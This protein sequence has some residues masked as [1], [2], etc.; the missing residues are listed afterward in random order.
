LRAKQTEKATLNPAK[1]MTT[2]YMSELYRLPRS[3]A[4]RLTAIHHENQTDREIGQ[5]GRNRSGIQIR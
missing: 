2:H 1:E 5:P 3:T 4:S